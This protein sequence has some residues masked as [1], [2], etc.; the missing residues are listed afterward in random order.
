[1]YHTSSKIIVSFVAV[2]LLTLIDPG[3]SSAAE[4]MSFASIEKE[5]GLPI[6]GQSRASVREN[7]GEP[8]GSIPV[9]GDPPVSSWSY[10]DF[11]VYF[12]YDL[13]ITSVTREDRLPVKPGSI[14]N[15]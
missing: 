1:M 11:V 3:R 6:R 5:R 15:Q 8:T 12:E 14:H 4:M 10:A 9:V 7:F 2:C 13:V